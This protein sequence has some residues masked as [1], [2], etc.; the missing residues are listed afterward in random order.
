MRLSIWQQFSSNHSAS[1]ELVGIFETTDSAITAAEE[2][3]AILRHVREWYDQHY[4][5]D[6]QI[7]LR[8]SNNLLPL[9]DDEKRIRNEYRLDQW[10]HSIDWAMAL[11]PRAEEDLI[12][13]YRNLLFME[14]VGETW[15]GAQPFD[16]FIGERA[17]K[18]VLSVEGSD[19]T[20]H[21]FRVT[22]QARSIEAAQAIKTQLQYFEPL[23]DGSNRSYVQLPDHKKYSAQ[24]TIADQNLTI[25][26]IPTLTFNVLESDPL[27]RASDFLEHMTLY[28]ETQGCINVQ[29]SVYKKVF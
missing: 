25:D 3:R 5:E 1:F 15:L 16:Q 19:T 2:L 27:Y 24:I 23:S 21:Y 22:C 17:V 6:K 26:D 9:T 28:L 11:L 14:S 13:V 10:E 8:I 7:T 12:R 4:D 18:M 29:I 20:W